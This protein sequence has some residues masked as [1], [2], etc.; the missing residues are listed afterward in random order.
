MEFIVAENG[1]S[2][3]DGSCLRCVS[4]SKQSSY[5]DVLV[6]HNVRFMSCRSACDRRLVVRGRAR[7]RSDVQAEAKKG[8]AG[9]RGS[10]RVNFLA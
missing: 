8:L 3:A 4:R 1:G 7:G 10:F 2:V 9:F 5:L 6:E